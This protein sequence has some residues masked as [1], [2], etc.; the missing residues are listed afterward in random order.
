[1]A[2]RARVLAMYRR[3]LR[4]ASQWATVEEREVVRSVVF[5]VVRGCCVLCCIVLC[6]VLCVVLSV[7]LC[8]CCIE[9]SVV[10]LLCC[11]VLWCCVL[12]C[13]VFALCYC[14]VVLCCVWVVC[15]C[16]VLCVCVCVMCGAA[17]WSSLSQAIAFEG[18]LVL[19]YCV[20]WTVDCALCTLD[21]SCN[22]YQR[23]PKTKRTVY[24]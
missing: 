24:S 5:C 14:C 12:F 1:M 16:S 6:V 7:V 15:V 20:L 23:S 19:L 21:W 13:V 2:H 4:G 17:Y 10:L 22:V 18:M 3:I 8:V 9:L 11:V